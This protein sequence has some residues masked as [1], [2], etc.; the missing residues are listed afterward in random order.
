MHFS[1]WSEKGGESHKANRTVKDT[2]RTGDQGEI[3]KTKVFRRNSI[4]GLHPKSFL[5]FFGKDFWRKKVQ[6]S[7]LFD[8]LGIP[9]HELTFFFS[10]K[11]NGCW[12]LA[13]LNEVN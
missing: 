9:F 4:T 2:G 8:L 11:D 1:P 3:W 5:Y 12:Y 7:L 13:N 6:K 10:L